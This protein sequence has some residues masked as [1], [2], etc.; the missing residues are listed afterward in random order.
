MI[1]LGILTG[2]RVFIRLH[3]S[4][5]AHTDYLRFPCPSLEET[6]LG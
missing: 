6:L 1:E 5:A 3:L 2:N 4:R